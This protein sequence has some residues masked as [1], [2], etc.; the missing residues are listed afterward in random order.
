MSV[1]TAA[2]QVTSTDDLQQKTKT[3][4]L[5][6]TL[7][8][9]SCQG[10]LDTQFTPPE[11]KPTW[12]DG[13]Q[14]KLDAAK[15]TATEW[16]KVIAPKAQTAAPLQ[17]VNY[18]TTYSAF[19]A[20]IQKIVAAYPNAQGAN[21]PNVMAVQELATALDQTIQDILASAD[22][23][24]QTLADWGVKLQA[25]HDALSSGA[26]TI[27]NAETDLDAD[28]KAMQSAIDGLNADILAENMAIAASAGAIGI[29]VIMLVAGIALAPETGGASAYLVAGTGGLLIVGGAAAWGVMQSKINAQY[30]E[31]AQDQKQQDADKRQIVALQG[32]ASATSQ[33][34]QHISDATTS[35]AAFRASWALFRGEL[36]GVSAKLQKAEVSLS[37]A[38]E[39]AFCAAADTEWADA[40][41][42]AQSIVDAPVTVLSQPMAMDG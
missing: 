5:T 2:P 24:A 13:L 23:T 30:Q 42:F 20:K 7:I 26:A 19:S 3:S 14:D 10:V 1:S 29:G 21:D 39:G 25:S 32:L 11:V 15:A 8:G 12:F 22:A 16:I 38:L 41:T 4:F 6:F 18:Q 37:T 9:M 36:A 33:A 35:L 40:A 27:Q 31:V 17:V 34:V 28:V